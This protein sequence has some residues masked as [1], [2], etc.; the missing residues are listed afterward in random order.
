MSTQH[1]ALIMIAAVAN[2]LL[3]LCLK[4]GAKGL[5]LTGP[6][7]LVLSII[8]SLWMWAAVLAATTL[9]SAFVLAIRTHSLSVTYTAVTAVAMISLTTLDMIYF[10]EAPSV[11]RISG[12][13]AVIAGLAMIALS[14]N[15]V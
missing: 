1:V 2:I 15:R 3:N 5:D 10:G 6:R 11:L 12:A 4:M 7:A 13:L 8:Q 14:V 9:L